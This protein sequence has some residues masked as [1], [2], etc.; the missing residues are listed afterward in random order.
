MAKV[1]LPPK[2]KREGKRDVP[3]APHPSWA[4]TKSGAAVP[5]PLNADEFWQ[6][7]GV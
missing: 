1:E 2:S 4:E 7:V 6:R 3:R 5:I